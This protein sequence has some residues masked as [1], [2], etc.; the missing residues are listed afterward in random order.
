MRS[1]LGDLVGP[2]LV[3]M[4]CRSFILLKRFNIFPSEVE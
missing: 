4:L 2:G 3:R 1:F